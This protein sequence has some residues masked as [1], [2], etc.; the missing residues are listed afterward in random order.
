MQLPRLSIL[1]KLG[2]L[3]EPFSI[4]QQF[5]LLE[6]KEISVAS[7]KENNDIHIFPCVL[8]LPHLSLLQNPGLFA[9]SLLPYHNIFSY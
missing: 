6:G 2:F 5:Y 7:G 9:K 1:Q 4:P 8:Q 3:A